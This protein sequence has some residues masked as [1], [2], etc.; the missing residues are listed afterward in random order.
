M[1]IRDSPLTFLEAMACGLPCIGPDIDGVNEAVSHGKNG[2][3]YRPGSAGE[4][5]EALGRALSS[6]GLRERLS[7]G[8][9]DTALAHSWDS[10]VERL[11]QL[12]GK[13]TER[14]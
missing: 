12:Y 4:L 9:L 14:A 13:L 10:V 2:F 3:L 6:S 1:C 8:A 5:A 11:L 7:A